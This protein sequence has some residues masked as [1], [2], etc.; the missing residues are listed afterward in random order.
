MPLEVELVCEVNEFIV[1]HTVL[2]MYVRYP[3]RDIEQTRAMQDWS[4]EQNSRW[5]LKAW[6][7]LACR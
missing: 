6:P 7:L 4:T 1:G 2:Q 3:C 5:D